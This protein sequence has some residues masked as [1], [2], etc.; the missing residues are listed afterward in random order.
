[1]NILICNNRCKYCFIEK[2]YQGNCLNCGYAEDANPESALHLPPGTILQDKYLIGK[3]LGQGG[4]GITYLAWDLDLNIKLAIK[5]Y[6]PQDLAYRVEGQTEVSIY[7][8]T[9]SDSFSYGLEK[10]LEEARTL[11]RF[12]EHPNIVSVRDFFSANRTAYLV[13]TYTEGITLKEYLDSKK[14]PL[15]YNE[16]LK[17]FIQVSDALKEVHAAG[18]LHRDISPDNLLLDSR[19]RIV[20][21]DFGA[22]RQAAGEKSRSMSVIMKAGY[23][24]E[25]QYRSKGQQGPWTDIYAFAATFYR[26]ITGEM[27]PEA[28]DRIV[29]DE[30]IPPSKLG[31]NIEQHQEQALVKALAVRSKDRFQSVDEFQ[32]I[33]LK[34]KSILKNNDSSESPF[35]LK[36]TK[37]QSEIIL[38]DT[39]KSLSKFEK[40]STGAFFSDWK[41]NFQK[42]YIFVFSVLFVLISITII[43]INS[44][45]GDDMIQSDTLLSENVEDITLVSNDSSSPSFEW[46]GGSYDGELL[47]SLPQG[48]G[49]WIGADGTK[50]TGSFNQGLYHGQGVLK[51]SNGDIYEG[52]WGNGVKHGYGEY[53]WSDGRVYK[54]YWEYDER[55]GSGLWTHPDGRE[56]DGN[57][58]NGKLDGEGFYIWPNGETYTG[59][60]RD[61]EKN[62]F[63]IMLYADGSIYEGNFANGQ[64][65]GKGILKFPNGDIKEG[66]WSNGQYVTQEPKNEPAQVEIKKDGFVTMAYENGHYKGYVVNGV[67]H[68]E[69]TFYYSNGVL[70]I[71]P[72]ENGVPHG[73][74][75]IRQP[76]GAEKKVRF[77]KG[78]LVN[79]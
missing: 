2:V 78:N 45:F 52:S 32:K 70:Y 75:I 71:G 26:A 6:L 53:Y 58:N 77:F 34:E 33:M 19:G 51:M 76:N 39:K 22:A 14:E 67:P 7:K 4:F 24:P 16:A 37:K 48:L 36:D 54:G 25:E 74:G 43:I 35:I 44:N 27:P 66:T 23:S 57:W 55:H 59:N 12:N 11:A 63:G 42:P 41:K 72:W 64:P 9:L 69:G 46:K 40:H 8:K 21:I 61:N 79:Y 29:E 30:L 50:Y 5:E 20:L 49:I 17:I 31:V 28:M 68:G 18:I 3:A 10:F 38:E 1:V 15:S 60:Y 47:N 73:L 62:G 13:M 56:Y 65:D